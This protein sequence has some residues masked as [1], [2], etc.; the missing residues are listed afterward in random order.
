MYVVISYIYLETEYVYCD[1]GLEFLS[2]SDLDNGSPTFYAKA[3]HSVL[4]AGSRS[5]H[6]QIAVSGISKYLNYFLNFKYVYNF[7]TWPRV[8]TP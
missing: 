2:N 4:W 5:A 1:A 7:K 6:G 8:K 3:H